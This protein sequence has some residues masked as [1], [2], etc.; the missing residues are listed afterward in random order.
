MH[1]RVDSC[2]LSTY[3]FFVFFF[4]LSNPSQLIVSFFLVGLVFD[5]KWSASPSFSVR[6]I[7]ASVATNVLNVVVH[8]GNFN[9]LKIALLAARSLRCAVYLDP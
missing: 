5:V 2:L 9:K 4:F 8:G 3:L 7:I 1:T 6:G